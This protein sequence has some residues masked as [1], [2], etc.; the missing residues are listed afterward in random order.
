MPDLPLHHVIFTRVE[1]AYS[2]RNVSG[3]QIVYQSPALGLEVTQIEKRLQCFAVE[4]PGDERYQFFWTDR[5]QAVVAKT[6]PLLAP[7]SEV[8]DAGRRAA[9]LAHA[10]VI[11]REAFATIRNDSF[12]VFEAARMAD[13]FAEDVERL[14]TYLR[15][16]PPAQTLATPWRTPGDVAYL[17]D[18]WPLE[19]LAHLFLLGV[20]TSAPG[21]PGR[22]LFFLS[23]DQDELYNLLF[24]LT[25]LLPPSV[26]GSCTFDTRVD[27][28]YPPAGSFWAMGASKDWPHPGLLSVRLQDQHLLFTRGG[29]GGFPHPKAPRCAASSSIAWPGCAKTDSGRRAS[30]RVSRDP[31]LLYTR[32]R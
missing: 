23:Q 18:T 2:P 31:A 3:Y 30:T 7:D 17:L 12:A 14:V 22:S 10:L 32:G 11:E 1:R 29:D 13:L 28:C 24:L 8:I 27:G 21:E 16:Q 4:R 25:F 20:Q 9:F 6:V 19:D 15:D 26:R 5:Q